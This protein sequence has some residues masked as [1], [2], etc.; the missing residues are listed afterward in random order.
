MVVERLSTP[1]GAAI[2][3]IGVGALGVHLWHAFQS[4]FQTL[5]IHHSRYQPLIRTTGWGVAGVL[6]VLFWLFPT[7]CLLSPE[8]WSFEPETA[9]SAAE[10]GAESGEEH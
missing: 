2:Y 4:L 1:V 8:R 7:F 10:S 3:F 9:G 6:A 5:G